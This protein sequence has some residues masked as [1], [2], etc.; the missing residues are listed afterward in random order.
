MHFIFLRPNVDLLFL[1][2]LQDV[3]LQNVAAWQTLS[4]VP[5]ESSPGTAAEEEAAAPDAPDALWSEFQS[6]EAQQ[7]KRVSQ[8]WL[9]SVGCCRWVSQPAEAAWVARFWCCAGAAIAAAA[10]VVWN[11]PGSVVDGHR[12]KSPAERAELGSLDRAWQEQEKKEEEERLQAAKDKALK[13]AEAEQERRRAEAEAEKDAARKAEE[14]AAEAQ[15]R[16]IEE[17]RE[18]ELAQLKNLDAPQVGFPSAWLL[19][20]GHRREPAGCLKEKLLWHTDG[21]MG[22]YGHA[23]LPRRCNALKWL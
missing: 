10:L 2:P 16:A 19:Q 15:R 12:A 6:R 20:A 8:R 14:A 13:E 23:V 9:S 11:Q 4:A 1:V 18:A 3:Q 22:N 17:R 7:Q 21:S 5:D